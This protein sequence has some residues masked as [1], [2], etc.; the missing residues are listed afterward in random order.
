MDEWVYC[1]EEHGGSV[2]VRLQLR[3]IGMNGSIFI[4]MSRNIYRTLY[5]GIPVFQ[6][7]FFVVVYNLVNA[8]AHRMDWVDSRVVGWGISAEMFAIEYM[9]VVALS[10]IFNYGFPKK[11]LLVFIV[12]SVVFFSLIFHVLDSFPYRGSLVIGLGVFGFF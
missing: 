7:V 6:I 12:S 3:F 2:A 5:F 11:I 1:G 9:V 8:L 4:K 10:T